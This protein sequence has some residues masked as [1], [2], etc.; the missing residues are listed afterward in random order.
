MECR[1]NETFVCEFPLVATLAGVAVAINKVPVPDFKSSDLQKWFFSAKP[2]PQM[3]LNV[4]I[5]FPSMVL[6][7]YIYTAWTVSSITY[8]VQRLR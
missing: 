7:R 8:K 6:V 1:Y 2:S 5:T 3:A 4:K